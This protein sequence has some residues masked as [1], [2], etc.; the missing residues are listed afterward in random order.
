MSTVVRIAEQQDTDWLNVHDPA[1]DHMWVERCIKLR[2]YLIAERDQKLVGFLRW[3]RFW[4]KVPYMDMI[5]VEPS[6]RLIGVGKLLLKHFQDLASDSGAQI[7]MTSC[8]ANEKEALNWH[9]SNNFETVGATAI[10]NFQAS[11]E[12]FL[13]KRLR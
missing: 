12:V 7:V 4:G 13:T 5:Y 10:P 11:Y 1:V 6:E 9:L 3:S 8:E 2:E